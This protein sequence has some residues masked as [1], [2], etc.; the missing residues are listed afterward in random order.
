MK[1]HTSPTLQEW[2]HMEELM[3]T[4]PKLLEYKTVVAEKRRQRKPQQAKL[5]QE[6][7]ERRREQFLVFLDRC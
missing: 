3:G 5:L 6:R 1:V 4:S 7:E 2:L